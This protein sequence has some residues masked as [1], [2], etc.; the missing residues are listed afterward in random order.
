MASQ[1]VAQMLSGSPCVL[2]LAKVHIFVFFVFLTF[3]FVVHPLAKCLYFNLE[4]TTHFKTLKEQ[5]YSHVNTRSVV[6]KSV[7]FNIY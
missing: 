2:T 5:D 6:T 4:V 3:S 7:Y 1:S